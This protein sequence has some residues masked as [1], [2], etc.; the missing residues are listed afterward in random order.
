M[1][2]KKR[3]PATPVS[4]HGPLPSNS[5]IKHKQRSRIA[6]GKSTSLMHKAMQRYV[7][8]TG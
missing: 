6:S 2:M 8:V 4:T 5:G 3:N 1:T 7:V